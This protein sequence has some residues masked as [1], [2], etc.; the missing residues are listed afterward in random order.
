MDHLAAAMA[1]ADQGLAVFP[2]GPRSKQPL[3]A[4][5]R[6]LHDATTD[7]DKITSWWEASPEANS[8][9]RT[10]ISFDAIDVDREAA[11]DALERARAGRERIRG[12]IIK[13]SKG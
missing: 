6:G 12:P 5:G 3:I 1:Y 10:G 9:L 4:G 11:I 2:L 8:G 7:R 13:T